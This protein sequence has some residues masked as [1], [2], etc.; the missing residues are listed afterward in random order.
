MTVVCCMSSAAGR[1]GHASVES[2][3]A[4]LGVSVGTLCIPG[5]KEPPT[6]RVPAPLEGS[7]R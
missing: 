3:A 6:S 5:L 1:A 7:N 4:L 2:I